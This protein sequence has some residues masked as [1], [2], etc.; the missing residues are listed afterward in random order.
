MKLPC[1]ALRITPIFHDFTTGVT[2]SSLGSKTRYVSQGDF[3][4]LC[5]VRVAATLSSGM[6]ATAAMH[7][8]FGIT[9]STAA[10]VAGSVITRATVSLGAASAF[11]PKGMVNCILK[12]GTACGTADG[13]ILNGISYHG[14]AVG[15][16]ANNGGI[17]IARAINGYGTSVKLP[18]YVAYP[19]WGAVDQ[20]L[21]T[22]D[23]DQGTG[24]SGECTAGS[25]IA[26]RMT[27]LQG[28]IHV[29]A[30]LLSSNVP[31]FI[32]I[33]AT[34]LTAEVTSIKTAHLIS[35]PTNAGRTPGQLVL[36]T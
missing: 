16:T 3:D 17:Q 2:A 27:E 22:A 18:H 5:N 34:F 35:Y 19:N 12:V 36:T 31:K 10:T 14:T 13:V 30:G 26:I 28:V 21:V 4:V 32:G 1:E 6:T 7:W 33:S 24:L 8:N 29:P 25:G 23:D 9:E 11:Q 15:A 20:V